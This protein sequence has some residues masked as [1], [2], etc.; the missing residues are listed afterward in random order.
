[1]FGLSVAAPVPGNRYTG[2]GARLR[3]WEAHV[4]RSKRER[5]SEGKRC[6]GPADPRERTRRDELRRVR[7]RIGRYDRAARRAGDRAD[8]KAADKYIGLLER[9]LAQHDELEPPLAAPAPQQLPPS[10][11]A[12]F[13]PEASLEWS[14]DDL[15]AAMDDVGDDAAAMEQIVATLEW[16]DDIRAQRDA[17][18]AA[19]R[20]RKA[21]EERAKWAGWNEPE[22]ASPLTNPARR[23][24]I[25]PE[26]A[27]RQEYDT[28]LHVSYMQ[29]EDDCRGALLNR[30]GLAA[31]VD[32]GTLFEGPASRV[33]KYGSEELKTW[34]G[35]NGRVTFGEWKYSW[36]GRESDRKAAQTARRQSLGEAAA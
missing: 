23:K 15:V 27:C 4:C 26:R 22:D 18:I 33:A 29:A 12:E 36:F 34:F 24:G 10:R 20:A 8:W 9:D 13:T 11:A 19:D 32:P 31:G 2:V 3:T 6:R 1:M 14:D 7:Q 5:P 16:R 25:S 35:R 28:F 17:D 30:E 21:E